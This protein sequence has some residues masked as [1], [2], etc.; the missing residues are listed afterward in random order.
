[1]K[2]LIVGSIRRCSAIDG[3]QLK[4]QSTH[5]DHMIHS[6]PLVTPSFSP[7]NLLTTVT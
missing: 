5:C 3:E 7:Q 4:K 1:M 6:P 2:C